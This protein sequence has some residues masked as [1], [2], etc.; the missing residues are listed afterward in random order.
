MHMLSNKMDNRKKGFEPVSCH[1]GKINFE[2]FHWLRNLKSETFGNNFYL[3]FDVS[4]QKSKLIFLQIRPLH[5]QPFQPT[6]SSTATF[7]TFHKNSIIATIS[8]KRQ[9]KPRTRKT[10]P[11][12][13]MQNERKKIYVN[14]TLFH[15]L[16]RKTYQFPT[17]QHRHLPLKSPHLY[18]FLCIV[19]MRTQ[20]KIGS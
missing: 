3:L 2:R 13:A 20:G 7:F 18:T 19:K 14:D 9:P 1:V 16:H 6:F 10:P 4:T 15:N 17:Q 12:F 5:F 8:A 11:T